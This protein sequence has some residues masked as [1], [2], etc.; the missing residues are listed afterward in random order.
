[1]KKTISY[2]F[3][4][5]AI[6]F[7]LI[8]SLKIHSQK[9]S[10]NTKLND[11][12]Y[13]SKAYYGVTSDQADSIIEFGSSFLGKS[14]RSKASDGTVLDCSGF[15]SHIYGHY[16]F[17]LP[18]SSGSIAS[19]VQKVDLSDIKK[20]DLLFF[21]GRKINSKSVGHV[22][23]VVSV[24]NNSIEMLHSCHRG[25]LLEN[26]NQSQYYTSRFLFAGRVEGRNVESITLAETNNPNDDSNHA[27]ESEK[28]KSVSLPSKNDTAVPN[29]AAA[30]IIGV[31]D[32]MLGTNYPSVQF[33]PPDDGKNLLKP[34]T[35][36]LKKGDVTFGNL[37]GVILS[38]EG[39]VKKCAN[40][41][42][43]YAF[44]MPD[45]YAN[46]LVDAGFNLLSVA[47]NHVGDF[48]NTGR[49]NTVKVLTEKGIPHAGLEDCPY[50]TFKRNGLTYGFA[51]FAP[52]NGTVK[53]ND[54]AGAKKI[55]RHLNSVC[56]IVIVSFHGGAEGSK[57]NHITRKKEVFLGENRGNPYE[58][59]RLAIDA[60]ADIVFGHGPHVTRA[61][62]IYKNRFIAY[63]L[64][65]FATY[66]RFNL[67]GPNGICPIIELDVDREGRFLSGQIHAVKQQGE[68]GPE[69]D[70]QGQ[71]IKEI[72]ELTKTDIP[73]CKLQIGIDGK[74][75]N[76][77]D[78]QKRK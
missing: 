17:S 66:G 54:Y 27:N 45:H 28:I 53:I 18:H 78:G 29:P 77:D 31:G 47:N 50:T 30:K 43:C 37:E 41:K 4:Q 75:I 48:G 19:V 10:G 1:M 16:G 40:P 70:S 67:S 9:L 58:F 33:L 56:D 3:I 44:K 74:I 42:N 15:V 73:E 72:I 62:D 14:Y 32:I 46:Y 59:A 25:I 36:I 57:K 26:Y 61:I 11:S 51:A 55:I 38:G 64:G 34:V 13:N 2:T 76:A 68:G 21:K 39:E 8:A 24:N 60:G 20:G 12:A 65:N 69:E 49:S 63:S 22:S 35:Q 7:F 52:N 5:L 71:V 23:M 6:S